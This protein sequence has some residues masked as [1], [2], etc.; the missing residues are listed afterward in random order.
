[1]YFI[2]F[3]TWSY[4]SWEPWSW[5]CNIGFVFIGRVGLIIITCSVNVTF[6]D[7]DFMLTCFMDLFLMD[8]MVLILQSYYTLHFL[9][10]VSYIYMYVYVY[11]YSHK[12]RGHRWSAKLEAK[13]LWRGGLTF[14]NAV[15]TLDQRFFFSWCCVSNQ[16]DMWI[17]KW[18]GRS[19]SSLTYLHPQWS[20]WG[21]QG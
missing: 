7:L 12:G 6:R 21:L 3:W 19:R 18:G 8:A 13:P 15:Y 14:Q 1:M 2:M 9:P 20:S 11:M 4:G 17:C 16:K 5:F 10:L